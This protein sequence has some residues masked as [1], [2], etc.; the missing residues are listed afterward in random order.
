MK[1][2]LKWDLNPP[3]SL[4][5]C[6]T[7]SQCKREQGG[8]G[9]DQCQFNIYCI[10]PGLPQ[11]AKAC[12][13]FQLFSINEGL[14]LLK[15]AKTVLI[16]INKGPSNVNFLI[17]R[18]QQSISDEGTKRILSLVWSNIL[19]D[20]NNSKN[21]K[22]NCKIQNICCTPQYNRLGSSFF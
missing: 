15:L 13:F 20:S 6:N 3:C 7:V 5:Y 8:L 16:L 21:M 19:C 1:W 18:H 11:E 10:W 22:S 4:L 9:F 12:K 17:C 14:V 2:N